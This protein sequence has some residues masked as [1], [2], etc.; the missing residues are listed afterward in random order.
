GPL[1]ATPAVTTTYHVLA[2]DNTSGTY[3]GCGAATDIT[4]TPT[5]NPLS[6]SAASTPPSICPGQNAQLNT[7]VTIPSN[8]SSYSFSV[9]NGTYTP[10]SGGTVLASAAWD[11]AGPGLA[12]PLGFS[13]NY[14]GVNY[15]TCNINLNGYISFGTTTSTTN[16]TPISTLTANEVGVIA[17]FGRDIQGVAGTGEVRYLSS[18]G[19]FTVQWSNTR[20]YNGATANAE[21]F[22]FQL[23]IFQTTNQVQF[24]YGTFSDAVSATTTLLPQIGLRGSTTSDFKNLE[25][26]SNGNWASPSIGTANTQTCYY[27]QVTVATKPSSGLTYTFSPPLAAGG[28]TYDWSANSNFLSN[29][30]TSNPL[31]QAVTSSQAYTVVVTQT[32]TGCKKSSVVNLTVNPPPQPLASSNAPVCQGQSLS[33]FGDNLAS[34][35]ASGNGWSWSGPS[36]SSTSQNPGI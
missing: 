7:T 29:T 4:I 9:S 20:R 18:G 35:Q 11:D 28:Y 10:I 13:F 30:N 23:K 21:S 34:G 5:A 26:L 8:P 2:V 6:V 27:N 17:A 25:V 12:I 16:Y 31:A 32:A 33:F 15:T 24:V 22:N 14:N 36:F 1:T 3:A 19:V